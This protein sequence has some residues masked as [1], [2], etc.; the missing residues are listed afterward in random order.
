M[1]RLRAA[2]VAG[3]VAVCGAAGLAAQD[4]SPRTSPS[5]G[6]VVLLSNSTDASA[7]GILREALGSADAAVRIAAARV[8]AVTPH[9]ELRPALIGALAREQHASAGAEFVRDI[10]H[11][12]AAG[13]LAFVEP[14]AR[15]LGGPAVVA[16]AEWFARVQPEQFAA[17]LGG[18]AADSRHERTVAHLVS[19]SAWQHPDSADALRRTWMA[20]APKGTWDSMLRDAYAGMDLDDGDAPLLVD[21]LRSSAA[22]VR[23]ETAWFVLHALVAKRKVTKSVSA[24]AGSPRADAPAWEAFGRELIA[25]G[26]KPPS[27]ADRHE[28][29]QA[30]GVAHRAELSSILDAP[31]LTAAERDAM[32]AVVSG[33]RD[34]FA[35]ADRVVAPARTIASL[36]PGLVAATLRATDCRATATTVARAAVTYAAD[37]MPRRIHV[38]PG[39]LSAACLRAWMALTRVTAADIVEPVNAD[40]QELVLPLNDDFVACMD[41]GDEASSTGSPASSAVSAVRITQPRKIK[42]V[43]PQYPLEAQSRRIQGVIL[44]Q[45]VISR[46]GCVSSARLVRAIPYLD[47]PAMAAVSAWTFEPTLLDGVPVPVLMTV[48]VNF[49]LR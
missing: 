30:E 40:G 43:K 44:V 15:R 45:A 20:V 3:C 6:D 5:L 13:D 26:D 39:G 23:E 16:L 29:V 34:P 47:I 49:Q 37:G 9:G 12:S 25:R 41:G 42:D 11:L 2:A 48:T 17:R 8:I 31:Q 38:D 32:R 27:G 18:F 21:A 33:R 10:L 1:E 28:L 22:H 46:R 24:E 14:Q 36:A 19:V 35:E 7:S 4:P